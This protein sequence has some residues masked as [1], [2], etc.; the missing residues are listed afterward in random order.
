MRVAQPKITG[1]QGTVESHSPVKS[2]NPKTLESQE[3]TK[4]DYTKASLGQE[5]GM[6]S[7]ICASGPCALTD[8]TS[9]AG[10]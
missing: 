2:E 3:V 4:A 10:L 1:T 8:K 6:G 5:A 7:L 9:L